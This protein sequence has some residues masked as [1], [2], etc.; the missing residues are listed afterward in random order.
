MVVI[1]TSGPCQ[2]CQAVSGHLAKMSRELLMHP[3]LTFATQAWV[4]WG[5]MGSHGSRG[6]CSCTIFFRGKS[7]GN[8]VI[9]SV[10]A[11][12][13]ECSL[14]TIRLL[15]N[16][17]V[18][19]TGS[20]CSPWFD[21]QDYEKAQNGTFS[22]TAKLKTCVVRVLA[23]SASNMAIQRLPSGVGIT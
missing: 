20:A 16:P 15:N 3:L 14:N 12:S 6:C 2:T 1:P 18:L 9:F 5:P 8:H 23:P 11:L 21:S 22:R 7:A 4:P 17:M 13:C 10:E 19:P